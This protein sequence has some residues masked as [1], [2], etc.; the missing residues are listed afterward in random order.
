MSANNN[1]LQSSF[2]RCPRTALYHGGANPLTAISSHCRVVSPL[3]ALLFPF[4]PEAKTISRVVLLW[5]HISSI[6]T[7]FTWLQPH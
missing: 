6:C 2:A 4:M 7:I 3:A 1:D 5:I